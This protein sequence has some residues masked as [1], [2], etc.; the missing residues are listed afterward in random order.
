[1]FKSQYTQVSADEMK[2]DIIPLKNQLTASNKSLRGNPFPRF[3]QCD[4]RVYD[5]MFTGTNQRTGNMH[6]NAGY[7]SYQTEIT[8]EPDNITYFHTPQDMY[9]YDRININDSGLIEP[10]AIGGEHQFVSDTR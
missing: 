4:H 2:V 3:T 7:N 9:P 8:L 5:K 10:G 6:I 1:M